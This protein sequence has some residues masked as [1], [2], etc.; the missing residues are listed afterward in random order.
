MR[1]EV[2]RGPHSHRRAAAIPIRALW[3]LCC[4]RCSMQVKAGVSCLHQ[5]A[6][7]PCQTPGNACQQPLGEGRRAAWCSGLRKWAMADKNRGKQPKIWGVFVLPTGAAEVKP[8]RAL[9]VLCCFL[10]SLVLESSCWGAGG[11]G[12]ST[13]TGKVEE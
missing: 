7:A 12:I 2:I 11:E 8:H 4:S 13:L 5:G 6:Q 3:Q 10:H 1:Q 9:V